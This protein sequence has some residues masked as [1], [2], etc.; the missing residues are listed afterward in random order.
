MNRTEIPVVDWSFEHGIGGAQDLQ[1]IQPYHSN[2]SH[3]Y[4]FCPLLAV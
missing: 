4:L 3:L 1:F 2:S